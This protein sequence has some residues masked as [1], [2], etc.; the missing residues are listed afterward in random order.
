MDIEILEGYNHEMGIEMLDDG[1]VAS[2]ISH[3][4][5]CSMVLYE[6]NVKNA[7]KVLDFPLEY[8]M[9]DVWNMRVKVDD[10]KAL[11]TMEYAFFDGEHIFADPCG[12][13]FS[14][15]DAWGKLD[16]VHNQKSTVSRGF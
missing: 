12:K 6:R 2:T 7:V 14:G 5:R 8:R 10:I 11:K 1:F 15:R 9:G 13:S 16:Q 4:A 3:S